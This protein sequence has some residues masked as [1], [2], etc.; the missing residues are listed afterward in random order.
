[1]RLCSSR[2]T[3][4]L[5]RALA[6]VSPLLISLYHSFILDLDE[7][8]QPYYRSI[9]SIGGLQSVFTDRPP[10]S[11]Y[12][13]P[14]TSSSLLRAPM[15]RNHASFSVTVAE[16]E[17]K[18]CCSVNC[19]CAFRLWSIG[20]CDAPFLFFFFWRRQKIV[21]DGPCLD[22]QVDYRYWFFNLRACSSAHW[23]PRV[24]HR[25]YPVAHRRTEHRARRPGACC[26]SPS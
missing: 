8:Y 23:S 2:W 24:C 18:T 13:H 1:M 9:S 26:P 25:R 11:V 7:N 15:T 19:R 16:R 3:L 17:R 21:R 14:E 5:K 22:T 6:R 4:R 20:R 12:P 10:A